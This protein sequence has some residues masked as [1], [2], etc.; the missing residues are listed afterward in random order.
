MWLL[1]SDVSHIDLQCLL[2]LSQHIKTRVGSE[3]ATE[4]CDGL[5]F[6]TQA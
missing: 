3:I 2:L 6:L 5:L 4:I 1:L